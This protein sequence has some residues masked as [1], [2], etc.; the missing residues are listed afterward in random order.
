MMTLA[1]SQ[2]EGINNPEQQPVMD[3]Q[4]RL[5]R[6]LC[7]HGKGQSGIIFSNKIGGAKRKLQRQYE[8]FFL[9]GPII[10]EPIIKTEI[11]KQEYSKSSSSLSAVSKDVDYDM[12]D[13]SKKRIDNNNDNKTNNQLNDDVR[14]SWWIRDENN[15]HRLMVDAIEYVIKH[16]KDQQQQQESTND[17]NNVS[18]Y[19]YDAIIGFSQGGLLATV[20][21]GILPGIQV[22]VTA[23]APYHSSVFDQSLEYYNNKMNIYN[24]VNNEIML[25]NRHERTS[26]IEEG[27]SFKEVLQKVPKLHIAG[28]TDQLVSID[29]TKELCELGQNGK[30]LYHEQGHLFPT[31]SKQVQEILEFLSNH[32]IKT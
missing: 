23:G 3:V 12:H 21:A 13:E 29:S 9:D 20:L 25:E 26:S 15:N 4:R 14:R 1:R 11:T 5:P 17:S 19:F 7:L 8:L 10:E 28:M 16:T 31:R 24:N 18:P 6:I 22:V 30:L 32:I 2:Q 27:L